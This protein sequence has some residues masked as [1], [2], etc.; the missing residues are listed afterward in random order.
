MQTKLDKFGFYIVNQRKTYLKQEA[1]E[2]SKNTSQI[3]WHFNDNIFSLYDWTKEPPF[4]I[5]HYYDERAKQLRNDYDYI[6]LFYSGGYD[7]HNILK[8]FVDN[9]L[10][11][12]EILTNIPSIDII[13]TPS[14]EYSS[15]TKKRI[16]QYKN[17]LPN[18]L[19]RIVEYRDILL[20]CLSE[21][22]DIIY[23]LNHRYTVNHLVKEKYKD[24][25][26]EHK[27]LIKKGKKIL[28]LFGIDKPRIEKNGD[29]YYFVFTEEQTANVVL[30]KIQREN[31]IEV[32]Y[33]FFYWSPD[34]VNI[35]IKQAHIGKKIHKM[36][37]QKNTLNPNNELLNYSIY[38]RCLSDKQIGFFN[39][40]AY[41]I[42]FQKINEKRKIN[43][44][45]GNGGRDSWL[46]NLNYEPITK[47]FQSINYIKD[48]YKDFFEK[49]DVKKTLK[50]LTNSYN[51]GK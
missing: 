3:K 25:F 38:P 20:N 37:G 11:I 39:E 49:S 13:S 9:N 45:D 35:L 27:E 42:I 26:P 5:N 23:T 48:N 8:T 33:E 31:I 2:W 40:S 47:H 50:C 43:F 22:K 17:L 4:D 28:Y 7:S 6:V 29:F 32:D 18:T 15:F 36:V 46:H 14:I 19:F 12:D 44:I 41:R 1:I 24:V 10:H 34:S 30:P 51:I 21:E 16:G